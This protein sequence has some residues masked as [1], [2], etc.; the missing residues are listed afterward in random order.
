MMQVTEVERKEL[1]KFRK[2]EGYDDDVIRLIEN[3]LDLEQ[4][5]MNEDI[6]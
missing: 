6:N 1:H 2:V 3:R 5:N 4:E